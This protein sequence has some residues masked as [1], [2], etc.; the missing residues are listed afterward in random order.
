ML[1]SDGKQ[2]SIRYIHLML[3]GLP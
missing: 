1:L 3:S 2:D